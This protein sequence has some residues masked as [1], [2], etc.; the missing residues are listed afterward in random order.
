[1]GVHLTPTFDSLAYPPKL[2]TTVTVGPKLF[3]VQDRDDWQNRFSP[4]EI[5]WEGVHPFFPEIQE[6]DLIWHQAG[7][8][9]RLKG[10][11]DFMILSDTNHPRF[12]NLLGIDSPG[13]TSFMIL[14]DTNHP[15]FINLLGID[16]PGLTSCLAIA[17][18]VAEKIGTV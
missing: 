9:S 14:S 3:P 1:V 10:Y 11:P 4:A 15:R 2:G 7:L 5:F 18:R 6:Q 12:I 17:E 8:Q 16:S 13:L